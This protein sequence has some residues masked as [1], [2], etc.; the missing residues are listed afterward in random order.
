MNSADQILAERA[1]RRADEVVSRNLQIAANFMKEIEELNALNANMLAALKHAQEA[2]F[3]YD[4]ERFE[5]NGGDP[6]GA[7]VAAAIA[8]AEDRS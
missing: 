2:L 1:E 7:V 3:W 4:A 8:K 5:M 6:V